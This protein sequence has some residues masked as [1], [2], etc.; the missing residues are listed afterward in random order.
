M[1][2]TDHVAAIRNLISKG[3]AS[4]DLRITDRLIG[5]FLNIARASVINKYPSTSNWQ[6]ICVDLEEGTLSDICTD[7][8]L[9]ET[10]TSL[11]RSIATIP[12]TVTNTKEPV[13]VRTID[14]NIISKGSLQNQK[15]KKYSLTQQSNNISWFIYNQS[16][17]VISDRLIPTIFVDGI[18]ASPDEIS[19]LTNCTDSSTSG[20]CFD[21]SMLY[22]IDAKAVNAVYELTMRM[23]SQA[24]R[25]GEDRSTDARDLA[26]DVLRNNKR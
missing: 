21:G 15:H 25:F 18:F 4:K 8:V 24:Y 9:P 5:H 26:I 14:G 1:T 7:C 20:N 11:M 2:Y 17:Y 19:N 23:L 22:P 13:V 3:A 12:N 10:C 16:L 6:T